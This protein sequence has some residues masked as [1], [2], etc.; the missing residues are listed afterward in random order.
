MLST[1]IILTNFLFLLS[2]NFLAVAQFSGGIR[3]SEICEVN[4]FHVVMNESTSKFVREGSEVKAYEIITPTISKLKWAVS[5]ANSDSR[6]LVIKNIVVVFESSVQLRAYNGISGAFMWTFALQTNVLTGGYW[7]GPSTF[8]ISAVFRDTVLFISG[9]SSATTRVCGDCSGQN[10]I[11]SILVAI[12]VETGS[13][14]WRYDGP[15]DI[16]NN[17]NAFGTSPSLVL[18]GDS[19]FA[20]FKPYNFE[21]LCPSIKYRIPGGINAYSSTSGTLLWRFVPSESVGDF[22]AFRDGDP[23][24]VKVDATSAIIIC[25]FTNA[26]VALRSEDGSQVWIHPLNYVVEFLFFVPG[27]NVIC[28]GTRTLTCISGTVGTLVWSLDLPFS[29]SDNY[30]VRDNMLLL[31]SNAGSYLGID[32]VTGRIKWSSSLRINSV[33][34]YWHSSGDIIVSLKDSSNVIRQFSVC[35]GGYSCPNVVVSGPCQPGQ[36]SSKGQMECNLCPPG[37]FSQVFASPGNASCQLCGPGTF[38]SLSGLSLCS[39]CPVNSYTS[40]FGSTTCTPCPVGT[41]NSIIGSTQL[42][43][44]KLN[45]GSTLPAPSKSC[46]TMVNFLNYDAIGSVLL[47]SSALTLSACKDL[48]CSNSSCVGFSFVT[49]PI[50]DAPCLLLKNVTSLVPSNYASSA[51]NGSLLGV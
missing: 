23:I 16:R 3:E 11:S 37:T 41:T 1:K 48:C 10:L 21:C 9:M 13:S 6:L 36:F 45:T 7:S 47:S 12:N 14:I 50:P 19:V 29:A 44:C 25:L 15:W 49:L 5:S 35:P 4:C 27:I 20:G 43:S 18:F 32:A 42:S 38:S 46:N 26:I 17:N 28:H 22:K 51:V 34:Q 39:P 2:F 30:G 24:V 40:V 31:I 8:I 33:Q